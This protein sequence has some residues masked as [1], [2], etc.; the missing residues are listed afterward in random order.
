MKTHRISKAMYTLLPALIILSM[1]LSACGTQAPA[2]TPSTQ[3][4][5][6]PA[7][8]QPAATQPAAIQPAAT[9]PAATQPAATQPPSAPEQPSPRAGSQLIGT[10]EGPEIV[11]DPA[12][13]PTQYSEAP[14]LAELVARGELPPVEERIG[15]DPLVIKPV[16]EIGKYGGEWRRG[17]TGPA[18]KWNAVRGTAGPDNPVFWDYTGAQLV[19]NVAKDWQFSEDGLSMDLLLRR[20]MRWSD[21]HPFTADDFIFWYQDMFLN[22]DLVPAKTSLM[23]IEGEPVTMEKVDD[24]TVRFN[25]P[26]PY[27][28]FPELMAGSTDLSGMTRNAGFGMGLYAPKHYLEQFHPSYVGL[29]AA[30]ARAAAEGYDNWVQMLLARN[31]WT[32]NPELPV[33]T[34]WV[35]VRSISESVWIQERNPYYFGVDTAGNQLPYIDRVVFTLAENLEVINL[36]AIAGEYDFQAR[37]LDISK[38]AVFIENQERGGYTLALDPGDYGGDMI[39]IINLSYETDPVIGDLF[40]NVDFRRALS[41]GIDRDEINEIFW[42]GTGVPGSPVVSENS[43][44]N[45]G[46]EYRTLWATHDVTRANEL[47]DSIGLSQRD[48]QGYR[49]RPDGSGRLRLTLNTAAGQFVQ[50]TRIGELIAEHY[51][52][53][54]IELNVQEQE[55]SLLFG[56]FPTN[57]VQLFAWTND[58]SDHM[59]SNPWSRVVPTEPISDMGPLYGLWYQSDGRAGAEPIPVLKE[60]M[61]LFK[62]AYF[63]T[64]EDRTRAGQEIW[65]NHVDQ[66]WTIGVIGLGSAS[67][68]VRV[69]KNELGNVPAR[70]YNSPTV[71]NPSISRPQTFFWR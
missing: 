42:L 61:E 9:Q 65:A 6:Q 32:I 51:Q 62:Q 1:L 13:F 71:K 47:L 25:F 10:L 4:A 2:Q 27:Y 44:Y 70:Q 18:D 56:R 12:L 41:L 50:Y 20:G 67:M 53:I 29:E 21:G 46:P 40:R 28:F 48:A 16:H 26:A 60:M 3:E 8:T 68:G 39:L 35:T 64:D 14:Q 17:F 22:D 31:E 52:E 11:T 49:L 5:T 66:V 63:M 36:R 38:L 43:P 23:F 45:P 55:R 57:D 69:Y 15:L 34:P 30:N 19:P 54:G 7:A 59:F 33:L 58:G 37:H 24:Y